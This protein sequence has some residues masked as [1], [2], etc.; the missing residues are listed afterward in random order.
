[1]VHSRLVGQITFPVVLTG[2][3]GTCLN[4]NLLFVA[5]NGAVLQL[6]GPAAGQNCHSCQCAD[7]R[8][9]I[10]NGLKGATITKAISVRE[11]A[12]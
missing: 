11:V 6:R 2:H 7:K 3:Y 9:T 12:Q 1:M 5:Q 4:L 8:A 10:T